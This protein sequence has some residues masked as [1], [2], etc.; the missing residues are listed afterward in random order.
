MDKKEREVSLYELLWNVVFSWRGILLCA[1][2]FAILAGAVRYAGDWKT[3]QTLQKS[4]SAEE[5]ET[6]EFTEEELVEIEDA[7]AIQ[8]AMDENRDYLENSIL[9]NVDPYAENVLVLQYYVDSD[10][11]F[12]YT[13][14]NSSDYTASVVSAY[15]DY[16]QSGKIA[17]KIVDTLEI[18]CE[19]R[20][21]E[22]LISA[23]WSYQNE[24]FSIEVI[25]PDENILNQMSEIVT[26]EIEGQAD[27][28]NQTIGSH[29]LKLL[30]SDI[31]LKTDSEL[32]SRQKAIQD[33]ITSYRTQLTSLKASM[34]ED[35][36]AQLTNEKV[37]DEENEEKPVV[38]AVRPSVSVKY[39][40][41]GILAGIFLGV[42]WVVCKVLFTNRLQ[43]ADDLTNLYGLR[44]FGS[45]RTEKKR[46]VVDAFL[47][48]L[49][50][51]KEKKLTQEEYLDIICAN[52][53]LICKSANISR[54]YLCGTVMEEI[55]AKLPESIAD[56]LKGAGIDVLCG[57][58][59]RYDM[60]SL[61]DMKAVGN[62][63]LLE[64]VGVSG[65]QEIEKELKAIKEQQV[66]ILGCICVE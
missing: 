26:S 65:Y 6:D 31:M 59:V 41:L 45:Y 13:S 64:Q 49:K 51:R 15:G 4:S 1:V 44:S 23:V 27:R 21:M 54:L 66:E 53:E 10:Y 61:R 56:K 52:L 55:G 34:T 58:D 33:I 16:V 24:I 38:T 14:D 18:D 2:I 60:R 37:S 19:A 40:V 17:E 22:E 46:F 25:Y 12:N 36:L 5:P 39:I 3:Y 32:A 48:K 43:F 28:I 9:M 30:S 63:V 62:T 35:Q 57:N 50:T 20:Y 42:V 47:W 7:K 8:E 29:T 11:Q